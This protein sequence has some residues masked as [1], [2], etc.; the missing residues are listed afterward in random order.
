[1]L[2]PKQ[3]T[4]VFYD[5]H[6]A[7]CHGFVRFLLARDALGT[8]F[9]YAP[10]QGDYFAAAV[11]ESRRATLPDSIVVISRDGKL[12]V[13]AAAVVNLL[14]QLGPGYRL[15]A[16]AMAILP[17]H[18]LDWCYDLVARLRRRLFLP[19]PDVCP[20]IPPHLRERFY[21]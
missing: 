21:L 3:H 17:R 14:R 11:P 15:L 10:L 1:M 8:K 19:P 18:A 4:M 5:G 9:G 13:K 6:C 16:A 12:L 7:L 20:M 2:T